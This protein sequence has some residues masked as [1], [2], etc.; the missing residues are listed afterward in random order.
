VETT[1]WLVAC[2]VSSDV[3]TTVPLDVV[4]VLLVV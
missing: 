2:T 4:T 1:L 3:P